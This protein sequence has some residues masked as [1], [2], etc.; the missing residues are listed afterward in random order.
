MKEGIPSGRAAPGGQPEY[1]LDATRTLVLIDPVN[2][3]IQPGGGG[4]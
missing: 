2:T 4:A 3:G 1:L